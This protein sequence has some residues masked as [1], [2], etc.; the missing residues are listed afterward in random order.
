M[1]KLWQKWTYYTRLWLARRWCD[2]N[3]WWLA[4]R[5][6]AVIVTSERHGKVLVPIYQSGFGAE[7]SLARQ[8][9][10]MTRQRDYF[11]RELERYRGDKHE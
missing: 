7:E 8:L 6:G 2:P 9:D 1:R 5:H 10:D 11:K 4:E 3:L